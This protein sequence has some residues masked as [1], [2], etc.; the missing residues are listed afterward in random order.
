VVE[1]VRSKHGPSYKFRISGH[2]GRIEVAG[3]T[4]T[5][6][7]GLA[8]VTFGEVMDHT[9][10]RIHRAGG[11]ALPPGAMR[12]VQDAVLAKVQGLETNPGKKAKPIE[13]RIANLWEKIRKADRTQQQADDATGRAETYEQRT[14]AEKRYRS[15]VERLAKME[16]EV[17]ALEA[18]HHGWPKPAVRN[19]AR[20]GFQNQSY[21]EAR[22]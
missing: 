18:E 3:E 17:M 20:G 12:K 19:R 6:Y 1:A 2:A 9:R 4:G 14:K 21:S 8:D 15:A 10:D 7:V 5:F 22:Q 11:G 13:E 16:A